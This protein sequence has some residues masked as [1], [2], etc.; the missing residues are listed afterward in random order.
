MASHKG[1]EANTQ[2]YKHIALVHCIAHSSCLLM[3]LWMWVLMLQGRVPWNTWIIIHNTLHW[4]GS[5]WWELTVQNPNGPISR[6]SRKIPTEFI[7]WMCSIA[8]FATSSCALFSCTSSLERSRIRG[9]WELLSP[10]AFGTG[11]VVEV[12]A[13]GLVGVGLGIIAGGLESS[14]TTYTSFSINSLVILGTCIGL[15]LAATNWGVELLSASLLWTEGL[16]Q[17]NTH[18]GAQWGDG[19]CSCSCCCSSFRPHW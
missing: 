10:A 16:G 4:A 2:Q 7:H 5:H 8:S 15:S 13:L 17:G 12:M 18:L 11:S 14:V 19:S 6:D 1:W 3:R 9:V